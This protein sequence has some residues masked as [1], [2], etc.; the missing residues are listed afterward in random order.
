MASLHDLQWAVS[1]NSYEHPEPF[2]PGLLYDAGFRGFELDIWKC[3]GEWQWCINHQDGW[4]GTSPTLASHLDTLDQALDATRSAPVFLH[5]DVKDKTVPA[6]F[7]AALDAV[8]D[9]ALP[10]RLFRPADLKA[11]GGSWDEWPDPQSGALRGR[12]IA[13]ISGTEACKKSYASAGAAAVAAF[14]D[15][16]P[17]GGVKRLVANTAYNESYRGGL[18]GDWR[19]E[20]PSLLW[21]IYGEDHP[22]GTWLSRFKET[23]ANMLALNHDGSVI[24]GG[25]GFWPNPL[26]G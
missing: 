17:Y 25:A 20:K 9:A 22:A 24:Q 14:P 8:L 7:A 11:A 4:S 5:L 10:G 12:I 26:C 15:F 18:F 19:C 21:R 3:P 23:G 16:N 1:H 13:V 2:D 6:G